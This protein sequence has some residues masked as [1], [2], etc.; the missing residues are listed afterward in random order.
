MDDPFKLVI[1]G[2]DYTNIDKVVANLK[3]NQEVTHLSL[4]NNGL[5]PDDC[6]ALATLIKE[7]RTV[8]SL[9]LSNNKLGG[10]GIAKLVEALKAN[11]TIVDLDLGANQLAKS[12]GKALAEVLKAPTCRIARLQ[13]A[14]N[15]LGIYGAEELANGLKHNASVTTLGLQNNTIGNDGAEKVI[16]ILPPPKKGGADVDEY[17]SQLAAGRT[18]TAAPLGLGTTNTTL[19]QVNLDANRIDDD[20]ML[21]VGNSTWMNEQLQQRLHWGKTESEARAILEGSAFDELALLELLCKKAHEELTAA[22]AAKKE[23]EDAAAA[24]KKA[25]PPPKGAKVPP[26]PSAAAPRAP[27]KSPT[28]ACKSAVMPPAPAASGKV[29]AAATAGRT[30]SPKKSGK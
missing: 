30:P 14:G 22:L 28:K 26:K 13:L 8:I 10:E 25:A 2:C 12:A 18:D 17:F 4:A 11:T 5:E 27:S 7:N 15:A 23:A 9:D 24:N 21:R 1:T 16:A 3:D 19:V 29:K 20:P 6:D